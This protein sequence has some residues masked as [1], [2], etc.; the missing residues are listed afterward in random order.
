MITTNLIKAGLLGVFA[1]TA[2]VAHA[3]HFSLLPGGSVGGSV[4]MRASAGTDTLELP[5]LVDN[6][7]GSDFLLAFGAANESGTLPVSTDNSVSYLWARSIQLDTSLDP[8]AVAFQAGGSSSITFNDNGPIDEVVEFGSITLSA[9][10]TIVGDGEAIGTPV[11]VSLR[12][13]VGTLFSSSLD[14]ATDVPTFDLIVRDGSSLPLASYQGPAVPGAATFDIGFLGQVGDRIAFEL[15]Y[16]NALN[17]A[18]AHVFG[19]QEL[20]SSALLD[21]TMSVT[22]VP[23]PGQYA[24]LLA[25]LGLIALAARRRR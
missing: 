25:G 17:M 8:R 16:S 23:E 21:G 3:A 22:A 1:A 14:G 15:S 2:G 18:S 4:L 9:E 6:L 19:T 24:L 10:L 12:G 5:G 11:Q 20:S 13:T 7:S